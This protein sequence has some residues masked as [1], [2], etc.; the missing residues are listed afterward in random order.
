MPDLRAWTCDHCTAA[1]L[2]GAL[3]WCPQC[4]HARY[5][6]WAVMVASHVLEHIADGESEPLEIL[7]ALQARN[8]NGYKSL[9][10]AFVAQQIRL[11]TKDTTDLARRLLKARSAVLALD[12][13][14]NGDTKDKIA[15]LK[16]IQVLGEVTEHKIDA[17]TRHVVEL[18]EGPPPK[19]SEP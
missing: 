14:E 3:I 10:L 2:D 15:L 17:V 13:A 6:S 4:R 16:G 19:P 11:L 7:K 9:T 8:I 12:V 1:E 18:H 5:P